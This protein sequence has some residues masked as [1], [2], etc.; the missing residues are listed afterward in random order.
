ML[1]NYSNLSENL[2]QTKQIFKLFISLENHL[3][4]AYE[5]IQF[6]QMFD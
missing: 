3:V 4:Y 1:I 6:E 2:L 5:L